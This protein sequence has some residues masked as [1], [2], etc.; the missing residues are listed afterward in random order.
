[1]KTPFQTVFRIAEFSHLESLVDCV[2]QSFPYPQGETMASRLGIRPEEYLPFTQ[3]VCEKAIADALSWVAL[4]ESENVLGFCISEPMYKAPRYSDFQLSTK[5]SALFALLEELDNR[6]LSTT[7]ADSKEM[8]H[9]YMLGVLPTF[10]GNGMGRELLRRSLNFAREKGFTLA[11]AEA[12]GTRSQTLCQS[13][14]FETKA[15]VAY[16]SFF[17]NGTQPFRDIK[18]PRTCI[19]VERD[20]YHL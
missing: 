6:Y 7:S 20:L 12:T 13:L 17:F 9:L 11:V 5:F 19:L 2:Q 3:L 14:G 1:M 8:F 4:D 18:E 15:S 16:D 10:S